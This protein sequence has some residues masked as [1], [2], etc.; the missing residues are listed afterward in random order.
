MILM[1]TQ[2]DRTF[3]PFFRLDLETTASAQRLLAAECLVYKGLAPRLVFS[4]SE[5]T[6]D[7]LVLGKPRTSD[8]APTSLFLS[9]L[10]P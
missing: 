3:F 9:D 1:E 2:L 4:G 7:L 6:L 10:A 8:K 5:Q